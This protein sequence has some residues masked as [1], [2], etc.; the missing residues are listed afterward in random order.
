MAWG[1]SW[2]RNWGERDDRE[3]MDL[4]RRTAASRSCG[5]LLR[6]GTEALQPPACDVQVFDLGIFLVE[7]RAAVPAPQSARSKRS[8]AAWATRSRGRP[9]RRAAYGPHRSTDTSE[10]ARYRHSL[11][12]N[13]QPWL[14]LTALRR[15][16]LRCE[17]TR[18]RCYERK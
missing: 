3:H 7:Y 11:C 18:R 13:F 14:A 1:A 17:G 4:D 8:V 6:G 12:T 10:P 9:V 16:G 15:T 2:A 5:G